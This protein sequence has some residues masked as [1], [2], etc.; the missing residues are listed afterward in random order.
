MAEQFAAGDTFVDDE[1]ALFAADA[2]AYAFDPDGSDGNT[3]NGANAIDNRAE[4]T[5]PSVGND[6]DYFAPLPALDDDDDYFAPLSLD[7]DRDAASGSAIDAGVT[8]DLSAAYENRADLSENTPAAFDAQHELDFEDIEDEG[9]YA[10]TAL[11]DDGDE[12]DDEK[13][14]EENEYLE[15]DEPR[16]P[17]SPVAK[18]VV[19]AVLVAAV[20]LIALEVYFLF[21]QK[22]TGASAY[23]DRSENSTF[24]EVDPPSNDPNK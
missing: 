9:G 14:P 17:M 2:S 4:I 21:W 20:V 19:I 23:R 24:V 18:A 8:A 10:E 7:V 1:E 6:D 16:T 13:A 22:P 12:A 11:E 5:L 3:P 15:A